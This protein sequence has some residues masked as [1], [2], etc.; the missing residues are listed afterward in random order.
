MLKKFIPLLVAF[1][2]MFS[3][4]GQA[5][6]A[7]EYGNAKDKVAFINQNNHPGIEEPLPLGPLAFRAYGDKLYVADSV[8]GQIVVADQ[9]KGPIAAVTLTAT[10]SEMLFDDIAVDKCSEKT[11]CFWLIDALSTSIVKV[12]NDGKVK[13]KIT[14]EHL[15]QP[16]R[17]EISSAGNIYVADKGARKI[18]AFDQNGKFLLEQPW[19]WTGMALSPDAEILYR[20]F[21]APES[22]SSFLVSSDSKGEITREIELNLGEHFNA[23]LW[24]VDEEKQEFVITYAT[25]QAYQSK[26]VIA[27][28]GFD[29][30]VKGKKEFVPPYA[31]NRYID[32]NGEDVW[33]G[34]GNF[35]EAPEGKFRLIK[36]ELP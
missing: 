26:M 11:I 19:E 22:D 13:K 5:E 31:M 18:F 27:R 16:F 10:P 4:S 2:V 12:G 30:E 25:S 9:K 6:V 36:F 34:A 7:F 17:I 29:G 14:S 3:I 15:I 1:F 32:R 33:M 8:G 35:E 28:V 23:E 21:F 20:I 24:W